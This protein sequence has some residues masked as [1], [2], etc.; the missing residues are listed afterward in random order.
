[1]KRKP[2]L[3]AITHSEELELRSLCAHQYIKEN[4]NHGVL[5]ASVVKE[6]YQDDVLRESA[7]TV[8]I[9]EHL[10]NGGISNEDIVVCKNTS[11]QLGEDSMELGRHHELGIGVYR[12]DKMIV[13]RRMN[14]LRRAY[15]TL[16]KSAVFQETQY[17]CHPN[18]ITFHYP[19]QSERKQGLQRIST[20]VGDILYW[21]PYNWFFVTKHKFLGYGDGYY[22]NQDHPP[23]EFPLNLPVAVEEE[24]EEKT[25]LWLGK[26]FKD[27]DKDKAYS[28]LDASRL[29]SP[30]V[31]E[32]IKEVKTR[33]SRYHLQCAK[34]KI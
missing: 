11:R 21:G 3:A 32:W 27:W 7:L 16:K 8:A 34:S 18:I 19:S 29:F 20:E 10:T 30:E 23:Q 14:A 33:F 22:R 13:D 28:G 26:L 9:D 12:L 25:V 24:I 6:R 1:M 15:S 17:E 5:A 4:Q 31:I 2:K